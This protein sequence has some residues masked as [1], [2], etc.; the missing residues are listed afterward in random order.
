MGT[1]GPAQRSS[2]PSTHDNRPQVLRGS[3]GHRVRSHTGPPLI[4]TLAR[5]HTAWRC[6]FL[7]S[8][9]GRCRVASDDCPQKPLAIPGER[10]TLRVSDSYLVASTTW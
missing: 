3:A 2:T 10:S 7:G 8:T 4:G 9:R 1:P 5:L 6:L